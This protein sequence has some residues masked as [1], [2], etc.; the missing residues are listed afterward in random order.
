MKTKICLLPFLSILSACS[1]FQKDSLVPENSE[2]LLTCPKVEIKSKDEKII[3]KDYDME[4]F[5]ITIAGYKGHCYYDEKTLKDKA[6][7]APQF[8]VLR[9]ADNNVED[10]HFSYYIETAVGPQR[11]LGKKTYFAEVRIPRGVQEVF[12][13]PEQG[14]LSIPIGEKIP[15]IYVGL[16]EDKYELQ[17]KTK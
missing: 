17:K 12:Y 13:M 2:S 7:I 3:Q 4:A 15:D 11:Y 14:E 10:V 1:L 8:K 6:V 16:N 9:L 5:L